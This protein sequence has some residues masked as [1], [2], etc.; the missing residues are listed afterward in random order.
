M[1]NTAELATELASELA[2]PEAERLPGKVALLME[3]LRVTAEVVASARHLAE[4]EA[5]AAKVV[6]QEAE[7]LKDV[8]E[9]L[10]ASLRHAMAILGKDGKEVDAYRGV[11]S[12]IAADD[13]YTI[14]A[15]PLNGVW[16]FLNA[17]DDLQ[18]AAKAAKADCLR[19]GNDGDVINSVIMLPKAVKGKAQPRK[20]NGERQTR[21]L[22]GQPAPKTPELMKLL[23]VPTAIVGEFNVLA[24][25]T[26]Y[27]K[28]IN[29]GIDRLRV[30]AL[31]AL[32]AQQAP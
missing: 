8:R 32:N 2:K 6:A 10:R 18:P 11:Y 29:S 17:V 3:Q 26:P 25:I 22:H 20:S 30:K 12:W 1:A 31:A 27:T 21:L 14:T 13:S 9:A 4:A 7:A 23:G 24:A 5:Q 15:A 16:A 19:Y 28:E